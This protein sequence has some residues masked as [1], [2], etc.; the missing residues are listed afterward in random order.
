MNN[1]ILN[2][3]QTQNLDQNILHQTCLLNITDAQD[4]KLDSNT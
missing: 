3:I 2:L 1:F 4:L